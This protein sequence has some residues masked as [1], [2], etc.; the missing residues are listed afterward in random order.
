[1]QTVIQGL[2]WLA[3]LVIVGI[4]HSERA[5]DKCADGC[6]PA[7]EGQCQ[8]F[9]ALPQPDTPA[10]LNTHPLVCETSHSEVCSYG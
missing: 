10:S 6:E 5:V 4:G 2:W 7:T 3:G 9:S 1:M 8:H